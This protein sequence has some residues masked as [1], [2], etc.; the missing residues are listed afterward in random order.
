M[1]YGSRHTFTPSMFYEILG[2]RNCKTQGHCCENV[3]FQIAPHLSH[4]NFIYAMFAHRSLWGILALSVGLGFTRWQAW[5]WLHFR[6][7]AWEHWRVSIGQVCEHI[8]AFH[9]ISVLIGYMYTSVVWD[10]TLQCYYML[11]EDCWKIHKCTPTSTT[12]IA[13]M[14]SGWLT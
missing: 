10:M 9:N 13:G 5:G 6:G 4:Q 11:A 7:L 3:Q 12:T 2:I 8:Q 1:L 14:S